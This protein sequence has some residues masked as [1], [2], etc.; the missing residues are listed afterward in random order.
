[1]TFKKN[2]N[3]GMR[4]FTKQ[5]ES[6]IKRTITVLSMFI[7]LHFFWLSKLFNDCASSSMKIFITNMRHAGIALLFKLCHGQLY[8]VLFSRMI[9][10]KLIS[11]KAN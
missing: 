9:K 3:D 5:G 2:C 1:M 8:G 4:Q 6:L 10:R 7:D 11:G